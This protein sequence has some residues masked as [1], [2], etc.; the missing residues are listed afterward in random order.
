LKLVRGKRIEIEDII[1]EN[2]NQNLVPSG[3]I[4]I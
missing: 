4:K 2:L 3:G 1:V